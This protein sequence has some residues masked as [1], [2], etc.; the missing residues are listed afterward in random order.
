MKV[1]VS[2]KRTKGKRQVDRLPKEIIYVKVLLKKKKTK[3][4]LKEK[5]KVFEK[6]YTMNL[7]N[8]KNLNKI[9]SQQRTSDVLTVRQLQLWKH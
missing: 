2:T 6:E 7:K 3:V 8:L 4:D 5:K 9:M 1:H